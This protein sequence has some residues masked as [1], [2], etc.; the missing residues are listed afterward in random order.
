VVSA[1]SDRLAEDGFPV[2][3]AQ[4]RDAAAQLGDGA[5]AVA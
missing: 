5:S 2:V 3:G 4:V 1:P